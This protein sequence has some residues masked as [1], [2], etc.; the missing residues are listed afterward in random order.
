MARR[1]D[2]VVMGCSSGGVAALERILSGLP[3]DFH[4][5]VVVVLH[6]GADGMSMLP[7][8]L[9]RHCRLPV[10]EAAEMA[11][12]MSGSV[13]VAPPGYHLLIEEDHTFSLSVDAKVSYARPS[14][15]VLFE[16]AAD[17][18]GE[19]LVGVILTGAN[20]DGSQGLRAIS[21]VGGLC[22][23][24]Q[25]AS[26]EAREMPLAAIATGVVDHIVPLDD[27][28]DFLVKAVS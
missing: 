27:M 1:Y 19:R 24:Q 2:A 14:I 15:D 18:Y 9:A 22:L 25:P 3:A 28:A 10:I 4:L 23:A 11:I 26:A 16:S 8:L 17:A 6:M 5:A 21:A 7:D 20:S 12:V 13:Y